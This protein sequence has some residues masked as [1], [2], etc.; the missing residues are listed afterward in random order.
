[1]NAMNQD[2]ASDLDLASEERAAARDTAAAGRESR[3]PRSLLAQGLA[4]LV[5]A[6]GLPICV[7]LWNGE[8]IASHSQP[9]TARLRF[10]DR[11]TLCKL[12]LSPEVHFGEAYMSGRLEFE[13]DLVPFLEAAYRAAET[14]SALWR[15]VKRASDWLHRARPNSLAGSRSN[16]H[17]HYDLG[18]DFYRLWLG[19]TMSYT[20][21]YFP[22]PRATLDQ[23]QI[24]KMHHVCRKL[25]LRAGESVVE[26]GCGW[27]GLALHMARHYGVNVRAF[28]ISHE[29]IEFARECARAQGLERAVEFVED[30][31]RNIRGRYDAFV[32]V[33]M[34]EHVGVAHYAELGEV[35]RGCLKPAGRGLLHSIGRNRPGPMN[36][37]IEKRIF[38]GAYP[39]SLR[40]MMQIFEPRRFS[41]LD[42][43]NLRLHYSKTLELWL[44][45]FETVSGQAARMF[46]EAFVRMW[47][48]Y[49]AGSIAAFNV[50]DLQ[51]FQ[52]VFA[53]NGNNDVPWTRA[54]LYAEN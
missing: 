19:P 37:W 10:R 47:R 16:V 26:A 51:L 44:R 54:H 29:Q 30:D 8:E 35:I 15:L 18:N 13:G 24:A 7:T 12:I 38:P 6:T 5:D 14:D 21:A 45:A 28:N 4:P 41:V 25:R 49:L 33:G 9:A 46:D 3:V 31:Y 23:A 17:H 42:V 52:V 50:G 43:E 53:P 32:S 34:L 48:L 1:M 20:C 11:A 27:G 22:D 39:P 2:Q 36:A 40:E